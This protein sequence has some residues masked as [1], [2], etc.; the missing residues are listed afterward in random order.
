M[1]RI[2]YILLIVVRF[3]VNLFPIRVSQKIA[4]FWGVIF[5][6]ILPIRKKTAFINLTLCFPDADKKMKQKIIKSCYQNTLM[7]LTEILCLPKIVSRGIDKIFNNVDANAILNGYEKGNG[8]I[9]TSA[10]FS[11]WELSAIALSYFTKKPIDVIVKTQTNKLVDKKINEFRTLTDN[12][13]I[14]VG[15]ALRQIPKLLRNNDVIA[16]LIDQ[17]APE[18]YSYFSDF[19]GI[20][21]SSFSGP[22]KYALKYNSELVFGY[23]I[24]KENLKFDLVTSRIET[25]DLEGTAEEK[26]KALTQRLQKVT[27]EAIRKNP[28]QWL[29]FHRRF[30]HIL[31]QKSPYAN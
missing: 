17:S 24:R 12:R 19:F 9:L 1:K 11:N 4:K 14:H 26:A 23:I 25:K 5:F 16:F 31:N 28:E 18:G 3:L 20:Q 7:T 21:V 2:E 13:M 6:Y 29:W 30:K 8:I 22:A 10:H 27:E 15:A